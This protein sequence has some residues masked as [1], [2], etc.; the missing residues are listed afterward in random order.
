MTLAI[1]T[2][3]SSGIV[4]TADS[5]QTYRN[6]A[7]AVR[8]GSDS[9]SKLFKL[10]EACGV[11]ISGPAFLVEN[12]LLKEVGFFVE[13]FAETEDLAA[14][15]IREIADK[16]NKYL[17][18]IF[19]ADVNKKLDAL[20]K[21]VEGDVNKV[22]GK[23]LQFAAVIENRLPYSYKD[24]DGKTVSKEWWIDAIQLLVAGIDSDR[25]GRAYSVAVPKGIT[26]DRDTQQC[27]AMWM[28][29][30]D[31]LMRIVKGYAPEINQI[32][33]IKDARSVDSANVDAQLNKLEYIINWGTITLQD[34]VDFCVL[35]T[36]TT[37][38][39]QRFSDG[40][41]MTPGAGITGV[42][43]EIDVA[44]ITP[45]RGFAWLKQKKLKTEG[46]E[47]ALDSLPRVDY[48]KPPTA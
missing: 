37:E 13:R 41:F 44:V 35:M 42:G 14:L 45:A 36:R 1:S 28:G 22:E 10:T 25:I 27:G 39:I 30:T 18:S 48:E 12:N 11:A 7:G 2:L 24:K 21:H 43:G 20:K 38:N 31:V 4:L 23:E 33:L 29:Q 16:L 26:A 9:A 5:R 6:Q 46:S 34:A 8:I 17:G 40:T 3:T 32:D 19:T 15:S 47:L